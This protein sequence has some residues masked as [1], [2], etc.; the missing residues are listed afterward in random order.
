[1]KV[2]FRHSEPEQRAETNKCL[3]NGQCGVQCAMTRSTLCEI[4]FRNA[5]AAAPTALPPLDLV[6]SGCYFAGRTPITTSEQA[7]NP[8]IC[9]VVEIRK[10]ART[11]YLV[12]AW[13]MASERMPLT[14]KHA[15]L[16][17]KRTSAASLFP[18][19]TCCYLP[20]RSDPPPPLTRPGGWVP[21]GWR[22]LTRRWERRPPP[23]EGR[24]M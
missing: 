3:R 23:S 1:M 2:P 14:C 19:L 6:D 10:A 4:S 13:R 5:F 12:E 8:V 16:Y 18:S 7:N 21:P 20:T 15:L 22:R 24:L 17:C 9:T 11:R